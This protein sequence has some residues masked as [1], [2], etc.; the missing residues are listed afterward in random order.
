MLND[1]RQQ[2]Y[3]QCLWVARALIDVNLDSDGGAYGDRAMTVGERI[4]RFIDDAKMGAID[5]LEVQSPEIFKSMTAQFT[6]DLQDSPL[7]S[8][9]GYSEIAGRA[10]A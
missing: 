3:D 2:S 10:E 1:I 6:Q 8:E 5:I 7:L 4:Q 9:A